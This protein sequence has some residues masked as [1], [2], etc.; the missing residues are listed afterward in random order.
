M[1][2][3]LDLT[4]PRAPRSHPPQASSDLDFDDS[5]AATDA[6]VEW[7]AR[8]T[9]VRAPKPRHPSSQALSPRKTLLSADAM[10]STK[11]TSTSLVSPRD[12]CFFL[13]SIL[14]SKGFE[15][16]P[17]LAQ[18]GGGGRSEAQPEQEEE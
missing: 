8:S 6:V 2:V 18:A 16:Q 12:L 7:S 4:P 1:Q 5:P 9:V 15:P 14:A 13:P 17:Q 3:P 10:A 11:T